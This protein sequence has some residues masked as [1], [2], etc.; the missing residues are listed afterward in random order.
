ML[1]LLV[2]FEGDIELDR[3]TTATWA[4]DLPA[5]RSAGTTG[6]LPTPPEPLQLEA[7][8]GNTVNVIFFTFD[9]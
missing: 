1:I 3:L 6:P 5:G 7:V 2:V 4:T 9:M 8:W